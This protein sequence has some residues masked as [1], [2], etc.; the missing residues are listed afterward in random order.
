MFTINGTRYQSPGEMR[1]AFE[2]RGDFSRINVL[3]ER[4]GDR[5]ASKRTVELRWPMLA[6][7]ELSALME[8]VN[9][10]T[11]FTAGFPDPTSDGIREITCRCT[12]RSARLY[13]V[14]DTE[15]L[16]ADVFLRLEEK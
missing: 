11:F 4:V 2:E 8:A 12:E 16:W 3:G 7:G 13:R 6:G 1:V 14:S 9:T 5:L 15:K 10:D